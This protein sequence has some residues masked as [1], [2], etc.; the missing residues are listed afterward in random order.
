MSS[1]GSGFILRADIQRFDFS[2]ACVTHSCKH[3]YLWQ[4]VYECRDGGW[5]GNKW[6]NHAKMKESRD[7]GWRSGRKCDADIIHGGSVVW[8]RLASYDCKVPGVNRLSWCYICYY[9]SLFFNTSSSHRHHSVRCIME[10]VWENE[11]A[12]KWKTAETERKGS[13]SS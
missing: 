10:E 6:R 2:L 4:L 7:G 9:V 5:E 13:K 1:F 8:A 12:D 11:W 3:I